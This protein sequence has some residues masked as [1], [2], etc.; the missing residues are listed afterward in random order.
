[1]SSDGY[2]EMVEQY[3]YNWF[4]GINLLGYWIEGVEND[5]VCDNTTTQIP[6]VNFACSL[7]Q[8]LYYIT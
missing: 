7:V 2:G 8:I 4:Y 6:S 5:V 1:M 3:N